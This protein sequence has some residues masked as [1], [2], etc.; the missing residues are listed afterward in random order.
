MNDINLT[1]SIS[2]KNIP[3]SYIKNNIFPYIMIHN[4][5][6]L[7]FLYKTIIYI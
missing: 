4:N 2:L 5:K 1:Y 7:Y 3:L 6:N